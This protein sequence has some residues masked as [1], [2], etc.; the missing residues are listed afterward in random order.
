M[1]DDADAD[2]S[3]FLF[4]KG[5]SIE[6]KIESS[7]TLK[8]LFAALNPAQI[9]ACIEMINGQT[10]TELVKKKYI[11]TGDIGVIR[12]YL[13]QIEKYGRIIWRLN[14]YKSGE[15]GVVYIANRDVWQVAV[16]HCKKKY[17]VGADAD[18]VN[19]L[20]IKAEAQRH[21]DNG[22]FVQWYESNCYNK[23]G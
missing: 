21:L 1:S 3:D 19:A 15:S 8:Q 23:R 11:T 7:E 4:D 18:L 6:D 2:A 17:Y 10:P 5:V 20:D 16:Q 13:R 12:F 9:T 22:D 14:D